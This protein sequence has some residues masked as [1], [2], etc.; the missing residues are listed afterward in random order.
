MKLSAAVAPYLDALVHFAP[1]SEM[2]EDELARLLLT[3]ECPTMP[4]RNADCLQ[5]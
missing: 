3:P 5:E 2:S 1:F 4:R